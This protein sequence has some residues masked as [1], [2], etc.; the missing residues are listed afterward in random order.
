[1]SLWS[2]FRL[3]RRAS[4]WRRSLRNEETYRAIDEICRA[5]DVRRKTVA[6]GSRIKWDA[7]G[8]RGIPY[9]TPQ[10]RLWLTFRPQHKHCVRPRAAQFSNCHSQPAVVRQQSQPEHRTQA[11]LHQPINWR[12]GCQ[13]TCSFWKNGF[14]KEWTPERFSSWKTRPSW[15]MRKTRTWP[16]CRVRAAEPW[17]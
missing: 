7:T 2:R 12:A 9:D 6:G 15:V 5:A 16:S 17:G 8:A 1:M 13:P 10:A 4:M 3:R 14:P 11:R